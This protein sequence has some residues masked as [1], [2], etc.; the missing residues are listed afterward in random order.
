MSVTS[1]LALAE[2]LVDVAGAPTRAGAKKGAMS[3]VSGNET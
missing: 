1:F 3:T 2:R